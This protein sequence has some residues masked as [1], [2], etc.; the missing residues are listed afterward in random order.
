MKKITLAALL[1]VI[2]PICVV[3]QPAGDD[4][5]TAIGQTSEDHRV[6]VD[7]PESVQARIRSEMREHLVS[8]H[9]IVAALADQ[10]LDDVAEIAS[11]QLGSGRMRNHRNRGGGP[12]R[13][14]PPAMRSIGR[15]MHSAADAVAEAAKEGNQAEAMRRLG[16][17][18]AACSACHS[19][20]R[21]R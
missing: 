20:Y 12:G 17:I 2:P 11:E 3:A 18:T 21:I 15:S 14:L 8:L 13:H 1:L 9:S 4:E 5:S 7:I 16:Q 19:S 10:R 6:L